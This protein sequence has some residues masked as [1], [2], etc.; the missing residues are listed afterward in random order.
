[1]KTGQ[2]GK[3]AEVYD[4]IMNQ[5][6]YDF[7]F[8]FAV[9]CARNFKAKPKTVLD[10]ACGTGRLA[11]IFLRK[12]YEVEG[13]DRSSGMLKI[14]SKRGISV[15]KGNI[16]KF[17]LEKKYDLILCV[18]DS[19]NYLGTKGQLRICFAAVNNHLADGGLF[20]FDFNSEFKI[21]SAIPRLFRKEEHY[22]LGGKKLIWKNSHKPNTWIV[23]ITI[24]GKGG[25]KFEEMHIEKAYKLDEIRRLSKKAGF[26]ILGVYSDFDFSKVKR[27]SLK[28]FFVCR[29]K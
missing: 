1:M 28:W 24:I 3:F 11:E 23:T 5:E 4:K 14:A 9:D 12:G 26:E 10:L 25:K 22:S 27:N 29:K 2:Y 18:F 7:Y 16:A 6:F 21:N 13:L 17:N 15:H 19:L 20:I 8:N